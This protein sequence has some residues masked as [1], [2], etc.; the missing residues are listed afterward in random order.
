MYTN[1]FKA[2]FAFLTFSLLLLACQKHKNET[3]VPWQLAQGLGVSFGSTVGPGG[4]LYVPDAQAGI[5]YRIDPKTGV[6]S[7]F[8]SGFPKLIPE[9]GVGGVTDVI[10]IGGT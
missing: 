6:R 4:D 2:T 7:A 9:V 8:A 10:F 1:F 3:S 5:I